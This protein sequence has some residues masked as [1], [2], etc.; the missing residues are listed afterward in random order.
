MAKN[1]KPT[2]TQH[3]DKESEKEPMCNGDQGA[4]QKC[5]LGGALGGDDQGAGQKYCPDNVPRDGDQEAEQKSC[6][7]GETGDGEKWIRDNK[8][9]NHLKKSGDMCQVK[10]KAG[11]T[12]RVNEPSGTATK[13]DCR[14]ASV[15][16]GSASPTV[17]LMS[18]AEE[19]T[20]YLRGNLGSKECMMLLDT[21]CSH[22]VMPYDLFT[23]LEKDSKIMWSPSGGQGVLADGSR[24]SIQGVGTVKLKLGDLELEHNFQLA[25]IDG[26]ILLGMDFFKKHRCVLDLHRCTIDIRSYTFDCCDL[27]GNPMA[28]GVLAAQD[29]EVPALAEIIEEFYLNKRVPQMVGT[30]EPTHKFIGLVVAASVHA[31]DDQQ[32][33]LR[34]LNTTD[35]A[36]VIRKG[37]VL[38]RYL[39]A[40]VMEERESE[41]RIEVNLYQQGVT[42]ALPEFLRPHYERWCV[43]LAERGKD[44]LQALLI[45]YQD[46]FSKDEFDMGRT[47]I[48]QHEIPLVEGT[49]PIKQK[50]YRYGPNQEKEIE[51]QVQNLLKKDLIE[52]GSG[53]WRSPVVL[54]RKKDGTWRFCVDYRKIN[55]VTQRDVYPIPRIDESLD[56]LGGSQWFT[57]LDLLTGYWQV[58][59]SEDAREK[60]AFVTRSGLWQFKVLPF[61]LT[62]APA[63]FERLMETIFRGLQWKTLLIYLDDIIIFSKDTDTHRE[64][65]TEVLGR[66]RKAGLKVK[67]SKCSLF[68][69]EVEYLGHVVSDQGVATD[70]K[71]VEAIKEWPTPTHQRDLRAFL[72]TCSYYR[73]YVPGYAEISRPLTQQTGKYSNN[74]LKWTEECQRA[75]EEMKQILMTAP[76]L[77]YPDFA[78]P[79]TLD[80]DASDV[81][82][83]AVLSQLK[84]NK[85]KVVAYYSKVM[86]QEERNYCTTRQEL[87]AIIKAVK[88]FRPYLYGRKFTVRTDH[89]SLPWLIK[90]SQPR[91]QTARWME[92]LAEFDLEL[93]HRKGL[94][95]NNAD[96]LSRRV[97]KDCK[98]CEKMW[99][100]EVK[101]SE[102]TLKC[103]LTA[104]DAQLPQRMSQQAAGLDLYSVDAIAIE[105]HRSALVDTG[106][107]VEIPS[108]CYGRIA[109]KSGLAVKHSIDVGAGVVDADYR[110]NVKVLLFNFGEAPYHVQKGEAVAQLICERIALPNVQ[111]VD[112]LS[113]T[114]RGKDG[115]G[116]TDVNINAVNY[117]SDIAKQQQ[118]D[119]NVA[120]VYK[121]VQQRTKLDDQ[122]DWK[123]ESTETKRLMKMMEHLSIR[124]D[125]MLIAR[126]PVL[127]RRREVIICPRTMRQEV[128]EEKH[129]IAHLGIS[130][131]AARISLDW[132]WPGM[133]A[134][135]RRF[136]SSCIKC[137]QSK[138]TQGRTAGERYHLFAGRPWQVLAV[139][140][141][142]PFPKTLRGNTQILVMSDHFSRWSDAIGIP[143][144]KADTVATT[145]DERIFSYWGIPEVIHTDQGRQFEAALFKELCQIW[146]CEKTRTS[147]YRPQG[148][149]VV[150]RLN[151]TLG[152]S[153]RAMLIGQTQLEW[154][155]LLPQIMRGIRATPHSTTLETPNYLLTGR[156]LRLPDSL[157]LEEPYEQPMLYT[158]FATEL[159][160]RMEEAGEKLRG[161]QFAIR[162]E[163]G[164]EPCLYMKGDLVWL[165]SHMK[166]KGENP[167]LAPKYVGIYEIVEVLPYHTYRVRKDGKE[168]VQHEGRI[169][170]H[171]ECR[172]VDTSND[173]PTANT[174]IPDTLATTGMQQMVDDHA[175]WKVEEKVSKQG[176]RIEDEGGST[177][178]VW[179]QVKRPAAVRRDNWDKQTNQDEKEDNETNDLVILD[180]VEHH[181]PH[182]SGCQQETVDS[183]LM[184]E[185]S[186]DNS[187]TLKEEPIE[188]HYKSKN[189]THNQV[190]GRNG[191][192]DDVQT[193]H[194]VPVRRSARLRGAPAGLTDFIVQLNK[195][196]SKKSD[197]REPQRCCGKPHWKTLGFP[198]RLRRFGKLKIFRRKEN[199]RLTG[200]RV[201]SNDSR[202]LIKRRQLPSES[203]ISKMSKQKRTEPVM[204]LEGSQKTKKKVKAKSQCRFCGKWS[205]AEH[206]KS[207]TSEY[208]CKLCPEF[209][210]KSS[211]QALLHR[212]Q[213]H[214]GAMCCH[215]VK[216]K[217][218]ALGKG[219]PLFAGWNDEEEQETTVK[220][221]QNKKERTAELETTPC[222]IILHPLP[223]ED[224]V[225][226]GDEDVQWSTMPFSKYATK[227]TVTAE[228]QTEHQE[229]GLI[230]ADSEVKVTPVKEGRADV[231]IRP[232][233]VIPYKPVYG[234]SP[235]MQQ[236]S[237][238]GLPISYSIT[239]PGDN[240][241]E[242][243][244]DLT[245]L[246]MDLDM[247][248]LMNEGRT[249]SPPQDAPSAS[250]QEDILSSVDL[251]FLNNN[252]ELNTWLDGLCGEGV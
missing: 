186:P 127:N 230:M 122:L 60:S 112:Q 147:P 184:S 229:E 97:C 208:K 100:S 246:Q 159:Q 202:Q 44:D 88:H 105:P 250:T 225:W 77:S 22:S 134:D 92:I 158:E 169:K 135:V 65:L 249:D 131:T 68:A 190:E 252:D 37:T 188:N 160:Q 26:K 104:E 83:G 194:P 172:G 189:E 61:G 219:A 140:L 203:K 126:I 7:G 143:D 95:H 56:A 79:F 156:E 87:L 40:D 133:Y 200:N 13:R 128:M 233:T 242:A 224:T 81:G 75:F 154:D 216:T 109:P 170:L 52:P 171:V 139:D 50:A 210:T 185:S 71:K 76:I 119:R 195:F 178:Q 248:W 23:E 28:V 174:D 17:F 227:K 111:I 121:L 12:G 166:K 162:Q 221:D 211:S 165:K 78:I 226:I 72:G 197:D 51:Q 235:T 153:L 220:G 8:H 173:K 240:M 193:T 53:A 149:S 183:R 152:A 64:R 54:A 241:T 137:Q 244:D 207:H 114:K 201:H 115:F 73:R 57:T 138:T 74:N 55:S 247:D 3:K 168:S 94:K 35:E 124:D 196:S 116:S 25:N 14:H 237:Q 29:I 187:T 167:K 31:P 191:E 212:Y 45:A 86:T 33:I 117:Q 96:G 223:E 42:D 177:S 236:D 49:Q 157:A 164:D 118:T 20:Y 218:R 70:P 214:N 234:N 93:E 107:Q 91:G 180:D 6:L 27:H 231:S 163:E 129:K 209:S 82:T 144:G 41:P 205:T 24:I 30:M 90:N 110:G 16:E 43:H 67:P 251:S 89:A 66:L 113:T 123:E 132:Y 182:K 243:V 232:F 85:E 15:V 84:E 58:E 199:T 62:S 19:N 103:R 46:V 5:C 142:G 161:Q 145:L 151:R 63:T 21:G 101:E 215:R 39:A 69:K 18:Q 47:S 48:V 38:G 1:V 4:G 32:I 141:C 222:E 98:Q 245:N 206:Q 11:M 175:I 102:I 176:K 204:D 198:N 179:V 34:L 136:V 148:N 181:Q 106:I 125:G 217:P 108:H 80:T 2:R 146:G 9:P 99:E 36:I 150:E 192:E 228:T 239:E 120:P 155:R 130:K 213:R 59:L 10:M 238:E